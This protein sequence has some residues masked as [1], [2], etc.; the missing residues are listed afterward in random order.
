MTR[1]W[2]RARAMGVP[3]AQP[4]SILSP[5]GHLG[6][7]RGR[8]LYLAYQAWARRYGPAFL[9]FFGKNPVVVLSGARRGRRPRRT[10]GCW[11]RRG[12]ARRGRSADPPPGPAG[13][14][15]ILPGPCLPACAADPDLIRQVGLKQFVSFHDRPSFVSVPRNG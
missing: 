12:A 15:P 8:P 11:A 4:A 5:L 14:Q 3:L 1:R 6:A 2:A 13:L 10:R 7:L 9:I